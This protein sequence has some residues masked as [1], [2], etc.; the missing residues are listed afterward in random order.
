[1]LA[2]AKINLDLHITG[3]RDDGY[4]LLDSIVAFADYGDD[5]YVEMSDKLSL[6][7]SGPF[8]DRLSNGDENLVLKAARL[9]CKECGV[10]PNLKFRLIKNLPIASGIGGGSA[11]AAAAIKLTI[12]M[13]DLD[14][15]ES[16]LKKLALALGADV[17]VCL[18][19][20][21][22]QMSGIGEDLSPISLDGPL[23][24]VLVNPDITV[25]TPHIFKYFSMHGY[26]FKPL[27]ENISVFI[28]V[29][30]LISNE[31]ALEK[32]ACELNSEILEVLNAFSQTEGLVLSRMSGSGATCYGVY[33]NEESAMAGQ[34]VLK[35]FYPDWWIQK[36]LIQ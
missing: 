17:P 35:G 24:C 16:R 31:N 28:G 25:S 26:S 36:V 29:D 32:P 14:I 8:A 30:D 13:L 12:Q 27:R 6:E 34:K 18:Y 15:S 3:K 33:E 1:M 4:H 5:L 19:S 11:D 2:P 10:A 22:T 21:A 7:V 23:H 9:I 20:K